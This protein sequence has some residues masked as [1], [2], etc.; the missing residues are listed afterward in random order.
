MLQ[1]LQPT[2]EEVQQLFEEWRRN[3]RRRDRIPAA[4][5]EAA[6]SLSGQHSSN[7]ISKLLRLNHTAVRDCI[8]AHKQ[9]EKSQ[10]NAPAFIELAMSPSAT[11]GECTIEMERPD[12]ERMKICFKGSSID[13]AELSKAFWM[14]T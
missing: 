14:R 9:G 7:K 11:V 3:K 12:G 13:A 5:W 10:G 2:L 8:G 1:K 4:L 6:V